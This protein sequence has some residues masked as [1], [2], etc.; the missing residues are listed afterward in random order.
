MAEKGEAGGYD[1]EFITEPP[2]DYNCAICLLTMKNPVQ[3]IPCSHQFC[4]EC[5]I[6]HKNR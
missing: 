1:A 2:I 5:I 4:E 3:T 6:R